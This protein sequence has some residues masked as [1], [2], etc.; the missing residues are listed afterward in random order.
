MQTGLAHAPAAAARPAPRPHPG[1]GR[2]PGARVLALAGGDATVRVRGD[3]SRVSFYVSD[4]TSWPAWSPTTKAATQLGVAGAPVAR[5]TRF[6]LQQRLGPLA[7]P[8]TYE[9]LDYEPGRRLVLSGLSPH[10]TQLDR[11]VFMADS[12]M[13]GMTVVRCVSETQ[14]RQWRSA[15]QPVASRLLAGAPQESLAGLQ[16]LL[17]GKHSPLLAP[18]FEAHYARA[19]P[20]A[21]GGGGGGGARR[22]GGG[23]W[24]FDALFGGGLFGGG[25]GASDG[26]A[27]APPAPPVARDPAGHY[28]ALGLPSPGD[29]PTSPGDDEIK[30]A[31]RRL[32]ME[33]HPDKQGGKSARAQ[34]EAADRFKRVLA[35]YEVL[36][37]PERRAL[38]DTGR[39]VEQSV[40]L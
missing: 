9:V 27:H 17:N 10:H 4:L 5:G 20:D 13:A 14:L 23:G 3:P 15:L 33:L 37:D 7:F 11:Y 16:R 31:Y 12:A 30:G 39:L 38:Y 21:R 40:E 8:M 25:G 2:A 34:R 22:R 19:A 6:E 26:P 1:R 18:A 32:V 29:A 35:A 24:S 36:R 28:S